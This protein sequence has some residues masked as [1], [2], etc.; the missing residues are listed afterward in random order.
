MGQVWNVFFYFFRSVNYA[1]N[2]GLVEILRLYMYMFY[3]YNLFSKNKIVVFNTPPNI[4]SNK[5]INERKLT[6]LWCVLY[7]FL[8]YFNHRCSSEVL[9]IY[10][11]QWNNPWWLIETLDSLKCVLNFSFW[12]WSLK[13]QILPTCVYMS[14][15]HI[16]KFWRL[17]VLWSF[18]L[19]AELYFLSQFRRKVCVKQGFLIYYPD[20]SEV[21]VISLKRRF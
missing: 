17:L 14:V 9:C 4:S 5:L 15:R 20:H 16:N 21:K 8:F 12:K 1:M 7:V 18:W 13:V 6:D 3:F 2:V 19:K 11:Y 10:I